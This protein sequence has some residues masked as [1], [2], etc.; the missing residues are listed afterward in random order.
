MPADADRP[1]LAPPPIRLRRL[2]RSCFGREV[3]GRRGAAPRPP[4]MRRHCC[5]Y[6]LDTHPQ[7]FAR[8]RSECHRS[9]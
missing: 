3:R 1:G 2:N 7:R 4:I 9:R 8:R 5:R 6:T